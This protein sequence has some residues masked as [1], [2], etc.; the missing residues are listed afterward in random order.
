MV[1]ILCWVP[2]VVDCTL[3]SSSTL[4]AS[5]TTTT[6]LTTGTIRAMLGPVPWAATLIALT[7][8]AHVHF[9]NKNMKH[10]LSKEKAIGS[11]KATQYLQA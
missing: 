11:I 8:A 7:A 4:A 3:T 10:Q 6:T 2:K 5:S 1:I 9:L